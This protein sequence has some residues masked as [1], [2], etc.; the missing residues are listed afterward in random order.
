MSHLLIAADAAL[1]SHGPLGDTVLQQDLLDDGSVHDDG[2]GQAGL[3]SG[4]K[5]VEADKPVALAVPRAE[6]H[7]DTLLIANLEAAD[8]VGGDGAGRDKLQEAND[9]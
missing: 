2:R 8:P 6:A 7:E 9:V 4:L 5:G 1:D 3:E